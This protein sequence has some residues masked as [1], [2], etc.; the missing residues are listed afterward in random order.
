MQAL[1]LTHR[2]SKKSIQL[3]AQLFFAVSFSAFGHLL[4]EK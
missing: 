4:D 2:Q 3:T 1:F